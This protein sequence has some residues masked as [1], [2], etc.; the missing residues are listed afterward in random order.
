MGLGRIGGSIFVALA[1]IVLTFYYI[2]ITTGDATRCEVRV[3]LTP[4]GLAALK[5]NLERARG[6]AHDA[7]MVD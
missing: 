7:A 4:Q 1:A 5:A 2:K 3:T 6:A